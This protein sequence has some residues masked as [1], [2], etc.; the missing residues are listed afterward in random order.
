MAKHRAPRAPRRYVRRTLRL[1]F[2]ALAWAGRATLAAPRAAWWLARG[3]AVGTLGL[4]W[5][6]FV[7]A[8]VALA[9]LAGRNGAELRS[10]IVT[11]LL[12]PFGKRAE[13][14][15]APAPTPGKGKRKGKGSKGKGKGKGKAK[16]AHTNPSTLPVDTDP[17]LWPGMDN[18]WGPGMRAIQGLRANA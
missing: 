4:A 8:L 12:E 16:P 9:S 10:K 17:D 7:V 14:R 3:L 11:H 15:Q 1:P 18:T 13:Q 5:C 2:R 6:A